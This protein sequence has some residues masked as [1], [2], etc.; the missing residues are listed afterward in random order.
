MYVYQ[1]DCFH[2]VTAHC[3]GVYYLVSFDILDGR[4]KGAKARGDVATPQREPADTMPL[5]GEPSVDVRGP[6]MQHHS[7]H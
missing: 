1:S 2:T 3:T 7:P 6:G 5:D 4:K